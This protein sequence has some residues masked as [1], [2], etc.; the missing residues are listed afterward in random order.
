VADDLDHIERWGRIVAIDSRLGPAVTLHLELHLAE[1]VPETIK[2]SSNALRRRAPRVGDDVAI[3]PDL[4]GLGANGYRIEWSKAP[5][6]GIPAPSG[7]PSADDRDD[8]SVELDLQRRGTSARATVLALPEPLP[9][10]PSRLR[11]PLDVEPPG[12]GPS[13]PVDCVFPAARPAD[14]VV[15]GNWLPLK[16]DPDDRERVVVVWNLWLAD[17]GRPPRRG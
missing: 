6:Y 9:D 12:G 7:E 5:Q 16:I 11:M 3:F 1:Q 15:V 14:R 4:G 2:V 8:D 10:D 13:Y 17:L